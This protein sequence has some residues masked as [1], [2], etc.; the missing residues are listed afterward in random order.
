MSD[1]DMDA[2]RSTLCATPY[3]YFT[4]DEIDTIEVVDAGFECSTSSGSRYRLVAAPDSAPH[5][6]VAERTAG[7]Q[8]K[9]KDAESFACD[10]A[11]LVTAIDGRARLAGVS[12]LPGGHF[13]RAFITHYV[14]LLSV[15]S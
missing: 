10:V 3:P 8:S 5:T 2:V 11:V 7:A 12:R 14:E 13:T 1:V 6:L 4:D 15:H 9:V